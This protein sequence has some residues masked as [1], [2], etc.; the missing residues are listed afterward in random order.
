MCDCLVAVGPPSSV[1]QVQTEGVDTWLTVV[2]RFV[3]WGVV[4]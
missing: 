2:M 4:A 1:V 3:C